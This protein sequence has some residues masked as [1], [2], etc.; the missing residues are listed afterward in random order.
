MSSEVQVPISQLEKVIFNALKGGAGLREEDARIVT[1]NLMYA[2]MRG[3]NQGCIKV[4]TGA[5][6]KVVNE[7]EIEI[8]RETPVS[9]KLLGSHRIGMAVMRRSLDICLE[10]AATSGIGMV[11]SSGYHSATGALG[12]WTR[13]A[14]E[15]GYICLLCCQCPEMV[16]PHGSY[17]AIFGTNPIAFSFP[18]GVKGTSPVTLDMATSSAA[19]YHL[20][21]S[22]AEGRDIDENLA[23]D[24]EGQ[25]TTSPG[26]A[27]SGA[28]KTFGGAKGSGLAMM[29]ELLAGALSGA[30]MEDKWHSRAGWGSFMCVIRPDLFGDPEDIQKAAAT[31]CAR[32]KGASKLDSVEEIYLPGERSDLNLAATMER[33]TIPISSAVLEQLKAME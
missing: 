23:Y 24:A 10:K 8:A 18:V 3:N 31:M 5:L 16:A 19:W 15:K 29:V 4:T 20:K 12:F 13:Q 2:E 14:A 25:P 6:N 27:L 1:D 22:H 9:A 33:G 7:G 11:S 21:Q 30:D 32:I 17:E 28:L 26:A